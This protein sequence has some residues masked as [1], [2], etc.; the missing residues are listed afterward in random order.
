[1]AVATAMVLMMQVMAGRIITAVGVYTQ[2]SGMTMV[3]AAEHLAR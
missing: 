3:Q 2:S 1:M